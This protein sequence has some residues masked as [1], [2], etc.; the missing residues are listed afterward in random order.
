YRERWERTGTPKV[1]LVGCMAQNVGRELFRRFPWLRLIAGPRSLGFVPDGLDRVM[2]GER[3]S[4]LDQDPRSFIDLDVTPIHRVN[5]WRAYVTIAHGCDNFCTYCIVPY[6]RGRF[7]SRKPA[8]ILREVKELVDDGVRE[9]SL[10]GQNVDTYGADFD[11]TYRF[12]DL[13]SDVAQVKGVDLLRFMT[14]YPSDFT[15]DVV[16]VIG[17]NPVI[18]TG[19]NLPI[20]SGSDKILK[21]MNR[22][23]SLAEYDETVRAIREGLP[24]VGL[25]SDLIVGFPGETEEDFQDSLAALEKYRFD[26]VHTAA[27]SPREGTPAARM[28]NQ[29]D[30]AEKSRRLQE[31]NALQARIAGEINSGLVGKTYRVLVDDRAHKGEGLLQGRTKTDKVV[32]FQGDP[33]LIGSFV[34][35]EVKRANNWCLHGEILEVEK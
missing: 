34:S 7:M 20:Q 5:H 19:I 4:L 26:Q 21:K 23:Y 3:V 18:C 25:T 24:D 17:K 10:L 33:S 31:V 28:D 27:Y 15:K 29:I 22:H 11:R 13:L 30:R 6:V 2:E 14:S 1:C 16:S 8:D 12:A 9:I 35:V 32:L